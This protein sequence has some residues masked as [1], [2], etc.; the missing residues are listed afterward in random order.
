[1]A[2]CSVGDST[3]HAG[4]SDNFSH[5]GF[6]SAKHHDGDLLIMNDAV[7][8]PGWQAATRQCAIVMSYRCES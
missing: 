5:I 2:S 7:F 6:D 4:P 3:L 8:P 1:M